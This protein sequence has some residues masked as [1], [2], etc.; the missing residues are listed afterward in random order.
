[1]MKIPKTP[2][3]KPLTISAVHLHYLVAARPRTVLAS[4]DQSREGHHDEAHPCLLA[5]SG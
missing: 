3:Y 5:P 4:A 1:M 2:R